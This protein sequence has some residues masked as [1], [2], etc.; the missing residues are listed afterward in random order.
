MKRP[1]FLKSAI[2][3]FLKKNFH[4]IIN[5]PFIKYCAVMIPVSC[6]CSFVRMYPCSGYFLVYNKV[7]LVIS[8]NLKFQVALF[9]ALVLL[10]RVTRL[11]ES[12][13]TRQQIMTASNVG[14]NG[15]LCVLSS[16]KFS[17]YILRVFVASSLPA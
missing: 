15:T 10:T 6:G 1:N 5:F 4:A 9:S 2:N 3:L 17:N 13:E 11:R 12:W 8:G 14:S 7:N 16:H